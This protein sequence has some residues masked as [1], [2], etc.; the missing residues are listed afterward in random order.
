[1]YCIACCWLP[2]LPPDGRLPCLYHASLDIRR[3]SST[4]SQIQK[5]VFRLHAIKQFKR[6]TL[7]SLIDKHVALACDRLAATRNTSWDTLPPVGP[8][9]TIRSEVFLQGQSSVWHSRGT[10]KRNQATGLRKEHI[11]W[12]RPHEKIAGFPAVAKH[13]LNAS[14]CR[15][16]NQP[17]PEVRLLSLLG[18]RK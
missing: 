17:K 3:K 16:A 18:T 6:Y 8:H 15:D 10:C 11:Q 1:M 9:E 4:M 12:N 2:N 7:R 14:K 5:F 13:R